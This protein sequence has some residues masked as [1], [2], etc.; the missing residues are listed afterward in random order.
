MQPRIISLKHSSGLTLNLMDIGATWLSCRVPMQAEQSREVILGCPSANDY[1]NQPAYIGAMIGRVANR[2]AN[3]QYTHHGITT[4]LATAAPPHQLHGGPVGF[5]K[6]RWTIENQTPST[7]RLQLISADGDQGFPGQLTVTLDVAL[8][9]ARQITLTILATS[10]RE[11]PVSI[12]QHA[13]F[14][15]DIDHQDVRQHQLQI[16]A[17][18]YLPVDADLIPLGKLLSFNNNAHSAFDFR[19]PKK[20]RDRLDVRAPTTDCARLR[21]RLFASA[22]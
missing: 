14:N 9:A 20:K 17:T 16:N 8:S 22:T 6:R 10:T 12:S 19:T 18:H 21:S 13:Y 2:I 3:S 11:T 1:A 4:R 15:L 5:D 7:V